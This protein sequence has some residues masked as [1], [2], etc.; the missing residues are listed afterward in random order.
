MLGER[1]L[2]LAAG[3]VLLTTACLTN[4]SSPSRP[5]P[6]TMGYGMQVEPGNNLERALTV[7]AAAGFQWAK[8]QVRWE[9]IEREPGNVNW[10]LTDTVADAA[11]A[12]GVKLLF[13]VVTAPRWARP[14]DSDFSVPGPPADPH[15][16]AAFLGSM[17]A[18]YKGK[19]H[20]YEIWN[21]QNL[22][23]EWGGRGRLHAAQYVDMLRLSYQAIKA[24]DPG[25]MII[26]GAPTPTGVD[27]G[28][29]AYDDVRYLRLMYQAGLKD[30]SDAIG[31]H[32]S[33]YNNPPDAA[34]RT[35]ADPTAGFGAKGHRSWFFLGTI[36]GY[37]EVMVEFGDAGKPLWLTESG[38][39][40]DPNP[41]TGYEYARD[42][43]EAEQAAWLRKAFEI[44]AAKRYVGAM[45]VWNLNF[46][47]PDFAKS[48]FAV[49]R[50]DW[51]PR[52]AYC[53]L[54]AMRGKQV[55]GC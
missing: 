13:S 26:S 25:T 16:F 28:D 55:A 42:N 6:D 38:W 22:W 47:T 48:A 29:N 41:P 1:R 35:Y 5:V 27:D 31:A 18:R 17:A 49:L 40:S 24:A 3:L 46:L 54:A 50:P 12:H 20:A 33:G 32:P 37:R 53:A 11:Y 15:E 8:V 36:E 2:F 23:Y 45:F 7:L 39:A 30:Y 19:V 14:V 43:T 51:T 34:W 44:A 10:L 4:G 21:E 9:N 52:P